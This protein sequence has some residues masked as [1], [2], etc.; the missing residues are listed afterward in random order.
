MVSRLKRSVYELQNRWLQRRIPPSPRYQLNLKNVFIFPSRF[1]FGYLLTCV[2]LFILG[3]NYQNNLMLLLCQFLL[4]IFL[5]HLF[6]SYRNFTAVSLSL[7]DIQ[8]VYVSEH[9]LLCLQLHVNNEDMPFYGGLHIQLRGTS[10]ALLNRRADHDR[11]VKLLLPAAQRGIFRLPRITLSS[12]YPLGLFRCWTHLDFNKSLAIY[13][14][15]IA[16]ALK[17]TS[18]DASQGDTA[19]NVA[20]IDEFDSLRTFKPGDPMNRVA[21][22]QAAKGG[23]LSTKAFNQAQQEGGW[24]SLDTYAGEPL[25][26]ALGLLTYQVNRLSSQQHVFGLSIGNKRIEPSTGEAHKH[27][28]LKSLARYRQSKQDYAAD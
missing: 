22:K 6:V 13:P 21:W 18:T 17:L 16:S 15:P 7:K 8:P 28:C 4:A 5:L 23:E 24:L 20:G 10:L 27:R 11:E 19:G 1:G 9:A 14:K 25:E 3:T 12:T 26:K 2:G